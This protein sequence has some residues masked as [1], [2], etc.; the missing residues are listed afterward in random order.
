MK[1]GVGPVP[2]LYPRRVITTGLDPVWDGVDLTTHL[3]AL[4]RGTKEALGIDL[5]CALP[6]PGPGA[7][8]T[9]LLRQAGP[10][11]LLPITT[12]TVW[13]RLKRQAKLGWLDPTA[14]PLK[15]AEALYAAKYAGRILPYPPR[16]IAYVAQ[17]FFSLGGS[18]QHLNPAVMAGHPL[19]D[20]AA[21]GPGEFRFQL[22][23]RGQGWQLELAFGHLTPA[24]FGVMQG[25][26]TELMQTVTASL[27]PVW[28]AYLAD[29]QPPRSRFGPAAALPLTVS[30]RPP[31][32]V[33]QDYLEAAASRMGALIR[34]YTGADLPREAVIELAMQLYR[35]EVEPADVARERR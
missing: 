26:M 1:Q 3:A 21:T 4:P 10:P 17:C 33:L 22:G 32:P 35:L 28:A 16:V 18:G 23:R 20:C 9:L 31:A 15:L 34:D 14:S 27:G 2:Q 29:T 25:F 7:Y 11:L 13:A 24:A 19:R 6:V 8:R 5:A 12:G 30:G